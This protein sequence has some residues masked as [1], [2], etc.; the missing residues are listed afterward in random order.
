MLFPRKCKDRLHQT[1]IQLSAL[2]VFGF[3]QH[4][5]IVDA[6]R[7][8]IVQILLKGLLKIFDTDGEIGVTRIQALND[9]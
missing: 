8:V 2:E 9:A 6:P 5:S 4:F 1:V 3:P 7:D